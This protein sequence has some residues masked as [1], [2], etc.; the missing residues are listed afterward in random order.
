M[1]LENIAVGFVPVPGD[2]V[3]QEL[4]GHALT[5]CLAEGVQV[6][7]G[8]DPARHGIQPCTRAIDH[9]N[10]AGLHRQGGGFAY[11]ARFQGV[12]V[13]GVLRPCEAGPGFPGGVVG[14]GAEHLQLVPVIAGL[15]NGRVSQLALQ[16]AGQPLPAAATGVAVLAPVGRQRVLKTDK[17][18]RGQLLY[19]G[20]DDVQVVVNGVTVAWGAQPCTCGITEVSVK[21]VAR[22][23]VGEAAV[24]HLFECHLQQGPQGSAATVAGYC[25]VK[26]GGGNR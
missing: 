4:P 6:G 7:E 25:Q 14:Q 5:P 17:H 26:I 23:Q 16:Y 20:F 22:R 21:V 15:T 11:Q 1:D 8:L 13:E 12:D 10:I 24:G 9:Q 19:C 18:N 2:G 3:G